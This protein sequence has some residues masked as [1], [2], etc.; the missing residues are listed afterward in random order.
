MGG[1]RV[2]SAAV[3]REMREM[4]WMRLTG[5]SP[6]SPGS[7]HRRRARERVVEPVGL[8]PRLGRIQGS[9]TISWDCYGARWGG[10]GAWAIAR[11]RSWW[12]RL[13]I[14]QGWHAVGWRGVATQSFHKV[15]TLH[16]WT[17]RG[18]GDAQ[19]PPVVCACRVDFGDC[20]GRA[21]GNPWVAARLGACRGTAGGSPWPLAGRRPGTQPRAPSRISDVFA[22]QGRLPS[23]SWGPGAW[24][25]PGGPAVPVGLV[26][27]RWLLSPP[28]APVWSW[29]GPGPDP[30]GFRAD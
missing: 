24:G 30:H 20:R 5:A 8:W 17:Q 15:G 26:W 4:P 23:P 7:G 10:A 11:R 13:P 28:G 29:A 9:S 19:L 6:L 14:S 3:V 16:H 2:P 25:G 12:Q 21:G 18:D 22:E 1:P 27:V